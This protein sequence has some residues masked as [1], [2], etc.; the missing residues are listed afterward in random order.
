[1]TEIE[2]M[3]VDQELLIIETV[4]LK[5]QVQELNKHLRLVSEKLAQSLN[6]CREHEEK[7]RELGYERE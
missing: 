2:R 5:N 6:L 3:R 4:C 1:M 7:L